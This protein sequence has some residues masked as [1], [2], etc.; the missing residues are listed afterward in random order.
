MK[1]KDIVGD[2]EI[3]LFRCIELLDLNPYGTPEITHQNHICLSFDVPQEI[4]LFFIMD[5]NGNQ[6]NLYPKGKEIE[7]DEYFKEIK[8]TIHNNLH[9]NSVTISFRGGRA[10]LYTNPL[11]T[12]GEA[13]EDI[14]Y[15]VFLARSIK[16][17]LISI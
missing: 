12:G 13:E 5:K 1:I 17:K 15:L 11:V 7:K 3:F 10:L 6:S 14:E 8:H 4:D 9:R 2:G 16:S